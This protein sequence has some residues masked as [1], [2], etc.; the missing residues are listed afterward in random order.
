MHD[1]QEAEKKKQMS[2]EI[3]GQLKIQLEAIAKKQADVK[4]DLEGVE[5]AVIEAQTGTYYTV[6]RRKIIFFC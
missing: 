6:N 1:Q 2:E 3:G 4:K 5:P